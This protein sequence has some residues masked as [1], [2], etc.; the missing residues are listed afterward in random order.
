MLNGEDRGKGTC[1]GGRTRGC[2]EGGGQ[3]EGGGVHV[4]WGGGGVRVEWGGQG[5]EEGYVLNGEDRGRRRV[6]VE[7]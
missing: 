7:W 4:E 3:V 2:V 1:C 5:E 6:H